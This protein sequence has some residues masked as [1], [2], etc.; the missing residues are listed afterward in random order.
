VLFTAITSVAG[1]VAAQRPG[2]VEV[3]LYVQRT[4]F[5]EL[6][7][8]SSGTSPGF[9]GLLGLYL[10]PRLALEVSGSRAWSRTMP[11]PS[12][13]SW[14]ALRARVVYN[15]PA[16]DVFYPLAG[17]GVV[18]NAYAEPIGASDVGLSAF[19]GLKTYVHD[20]VAFRSDL[21][22]D[23]V[24]APFNAGDTFA[25]RAVSRHLNWTL[26]AGLSV[27]V[28]RGR[29]QAAGHHRDRP[30]PVES[31]WSARHHGG[32]LPEAPPSP[33]E[34]D[35]DG[36]HEELEPP[37]P[38]ELP[39]LESV[40]FETAS[41]DLTV[42]SRRMLDAVATMLTLRP[43]VHVRV[44]GHT[45]STGPRPYNL[46]LSRDRAETVARYLADRGVDRRRME[47]RGFGPDQPAATNGTPDGRR[48]NRR[49]ELERIQQP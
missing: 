13:A 7:T 5:D 43:D 24:G 30:A 26:S 17:V 10:A 2:T 28:R 40:Y 31:A 42:E 9:G 22:M 47:R 48:Q 45:D 27:H 3:G 25:G 15:V 38:E 41:A 36:P 18:R 29:A 19:V 37:E 14:T 8:L 4:A 23:Y 16:T 32:S 1:P 11:R 12:E 35:Q 34:T 46:R 39:A 49:V 44:S 20:R 21:H 6:T 33:A